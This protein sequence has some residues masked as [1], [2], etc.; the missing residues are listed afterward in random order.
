MVAGNALV[1]RA[2]RDHDAHV[3]ADCV[4]ACEGLFRRRERKQPARREAP[5][6]PASSSP[7]WMITSSVRIG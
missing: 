3:C 1:Q 4:E 7:T 6:A 2:M 5:D